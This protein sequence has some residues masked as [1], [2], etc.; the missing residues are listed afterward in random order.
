M[1]RGSQLLVFN[2]FIEFNDFTELDARVQGRP[3]FFSMLLLDFSNDVLL[4]L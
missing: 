3:S 1:R 4:A 2:D